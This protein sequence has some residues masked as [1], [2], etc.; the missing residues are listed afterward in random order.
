MTKFVYSMQFPP[1]VRQNWIGSSFCGCKLTTMYQYVTMCPTV[2]LL[3]ATKQ[4]VF[5]PL[6]DCVVYLSASRPNFFDRQFFQRCLAFSSFDCIRYLYWCISS[7][8]GSTLT[9]TSYNVSGL[10]SIYSAM[11]CIDIII[12]GVVWLIS[13]CVTR[14]TSL[15]ATLGVIS[16]FFSGIKFTFIASACSWCFLVGY[17]CVVGALTCFG[18]S[19]KSCVLIQCSLVLLVIF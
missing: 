4:M 12:G 5:F 1:K 16:G 19:G 11:L 6:S 18:M 3:Y 15:G 17:Q 8:Y 9:L 10:S 14:C 2:M 13:S 7:V